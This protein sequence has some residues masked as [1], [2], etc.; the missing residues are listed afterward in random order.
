MDRQGPPSFF[1]KETI[2]RYTLVLPIVVYFSL[3]TLYPMIQDLYSGIASKAIFNLSSIPDFWQ[4]LVN[5]ALFSASTTLIEFFAGLFLAILIERSGRLSSLFLV[6][7]ILPLLVSPV[8]VGVIWLLILDPQFGP[9]NYFLSFLGIKAPF[10]VGSQSTI[11][12]S[13]IIASSWEETPLVLLTIYA[14]LKSIPSQI[15]D[16][17]QV[18]GL[19]TSSFLR[20]VALPMIKPSLAVAAL[21]ALMT[22]FRSFDLVYMFAINGP[23][24]YVQTLPYLLYQVSFVSSFQQYGYAISIII[25]VIALV[26]TF[27]LLRYL[28]IPERLG[29]VKRKAKK[30]R[31]ISFLR[32]PEFSLRLPSIPRKFASF[33]KYF[34]LSAFAIV[35]IFPFYWTFVTS[36]KNFDELFPSN[37]KVVLLPTMIDF[38]GWKIALNEMY[39]YI[40]TSLAVTVSVIVVTLLISIPASYSISRYKTTGTG[41][42]SWSI[43]VNSIP[44]VIFVLP[45]FNTVTTLHIYDTW[46]ALILTYPVFTI[47]IVTWLLVGFVED[48]PKEIDD[49]ARIDGL[50]T[51]SI[52]TRVMVPLMKPGLV[53]CIIITAINCWH[54]FLLTLT[55]GATVFNGNVPHGARGVTVYIS[56]FISATGINWSTISAAAVIVSLPLILMIIFLQRYYISGLTSGAVKI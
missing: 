1:S 51:F 31:K 48:I 14:A 10:W 21:L 39:G 34:I 11:M 8:A 7:F 37:G 4:T 28:N 18:D 29:L 5:T 30:A 12:P 54:E 16:A 49:A 43:I 53:A 27:L 2:T 47:P 33:L 36:L 15:Y 32:F 38:T 44:S 13:A 25:M 17:A 56:N 9:L 26:P 42:I 52:L 46:V 20:R 24:V 35:T 50:G 55:L 41:L 45:F 23:F 40:I 3:F 22:S 19:S 6:C